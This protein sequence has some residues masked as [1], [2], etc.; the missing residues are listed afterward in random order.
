MASAEKLTIALRPEIAGFICRSADAGEYALASQAIRHAVR[1]LKERRDVP[2]YALE[3]LLE[4]V[5]KRLVRAPSDHTSMTDV[6][7]AVRG[8]SHCPENSLGVPPILRAKH[9]DEDLIAEIA[10]KDLTT[11]NQVLMP[12]TDA[13]DKWPV[14]PTRALPTMMVHRACD[15]QK[16]I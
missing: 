16:I 13:G 5:D 3:N 7:V 11:A 12:S 6:K 14:I 4:L 1:E 2:G 8:R 10:A 15:S 9:R